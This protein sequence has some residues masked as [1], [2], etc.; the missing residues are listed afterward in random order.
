VGD[1]DYGSEFDF[2][3]LL[4]LRDGFYA[5]FKYANYQAV[6]FATDRE[7]FIFGLGYEY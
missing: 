3:T 7:K 1:I 6:S 2:Y 5:Q 4:P